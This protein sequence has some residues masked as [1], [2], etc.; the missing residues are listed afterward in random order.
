MRFA[1]SNDILLEDDGSGYDIVRFGRPLWASRWISTGSEGDNQRKFEDMIEFAKFKLLGGT[2]HWDS[3]PDIKRKATFAIIACIATL[4]ISPVSSEAPDL[5][6]SHMAILVAIDDDRKKHLIAYPSEPVLSEAA[7]E[8]LSENGAELKV[9]TEL[10]AVNK[11]SGILDAG[12]Q[13]ELVVM[14]LFLSAWRCLIC[15]ERD[16]GIKVCIKHFSSIII[17]ITLF[18]SICHV[19]FRSLSDVQFLTFFKNFLQRSFHNRTFLT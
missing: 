8:V 7:L 18:S 1:C 2:F 14:L 9:L 17:C 4:Y 16:K 12:C 6:K 13:G 5:V 3:D 10:D 11:S 15:S 19:R